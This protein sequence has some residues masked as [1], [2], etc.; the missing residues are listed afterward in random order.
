MK[1][2]R[3]PPLVKSPLRLRPRRVICSGATPLRTPLPA[4][5]TKIWMQNRAS[6]IK[7]SSGIR[8]EY[9]TISCEVKVLQRMVQ[10]E[11]GK[12]CSN[13]AGLGGFSGASFGSQFERG[14]FYDEYCAK[15]NERLKRKLSS[16]ITDENEEPKTACD[17]GLLM[18][19]AKKEETKKRATAKKSIQQTAASNLVNRSEHPRYALR[20]MKK[21]PLPVPMS[22]ENSVGVG[23][24]KTRAQARRN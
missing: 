23:Q 12:S 9:R 11:L 22:V 17:L 1:S 16:A 2:D 15:R 6:N 13:G 18:Q 8:P 14:K 20:S 5:A 4:S 10:E 3:K 21:P 7:E 24:R 19:S